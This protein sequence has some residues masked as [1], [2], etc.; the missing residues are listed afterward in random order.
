MT[1]EY[2]TLNTVMWPACVDVIVCRK[3]LKLHTI[4]VIIMFMVLK[5]LLVMVLQLLIVR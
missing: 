5:L 2:K 3:M 4:I 1:I